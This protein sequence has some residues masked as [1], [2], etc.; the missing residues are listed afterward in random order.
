MDLFDTIVSLESILTSQFR[1][2]YLSLLT[3]ENSPNVVVTIASKQFEDVPLE[4]RIDMVFRM[5]DS[6]DP[7]M[8]KWIIVQPHTTSEIL[9][10]IDHGKL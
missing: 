6:H 7:N 9:D 10:L 1:P 2:T 8:R 4:K 3:E 5:I